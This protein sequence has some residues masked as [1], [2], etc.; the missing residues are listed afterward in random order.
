M[1]KLAQKR[2]SQ[3][4]QTGL[5]KKNSLSYGGTLLTKRKNRTYARPISTQQ[6]MHLVLR[7]S[8][9]VDEMSFKTSR[10]QRK[11]KEIINKFS[12]KYGIQ[13]LSLANVGNHLH[14]HVK[15]TKRQGYIRFIRAITSAIAMAITGR[16]RWNQL[17]EK[18]KFWDYR[19]FTRIIMGF[20]DLL[21][22]QDYIQINQLEGLGLKRI[23]ARRM[24]AQKRARLC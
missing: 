6:S 1:S 19:P 14:F 10:H 16:N 24:I 11:I 20:R 18:K 3:Q 4:S 15:I 7:S 13:I 22:L 17:S 2:A 9:A 5:F 23:E 12:T 8:K 21:G